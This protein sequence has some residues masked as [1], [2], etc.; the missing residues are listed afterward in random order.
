MVLTH[1]KQSLKTIGIVLGSLD[2][3]CQTN[4]L[5]GIREFAEAHNIQLITFVGV[6]LD[7]ESHYSNS[8]QM[9]G[10]L[11]SSSNVDAVIC[12]GGAMTNL[13]SK[14]EL[15]D[16]T[17]RFLH[18][19][20]VNIANSLSNHINI[21]IDNQFS[22]YT[23]VSH[24]IECHHCKHL[25]FISGPLEHEEAN[26][27][28]LG[29]KAALKEHNILIDHEL[30]FFG[31]FSTYSGKDAVKSL[32][33]EKNRMVDAF[34]CIND[35]TAYGVID[36]LKE[37]NISVPMDVRVTGFDDLPQSTISPTLT[38][39]A[40]PF[41]LL[42][43]K[44]AETCYD[45]LLKRSLP[46]VV[47]VIAHPI[48]RESCGCCSSPLNITPFWEPEQNVSEPF[49]QLTH[50]LRLE[51]LV[52][53]LSPKISHTHRPKILKQLD[54]FMD[55]LV[56]EKSF[57][58]PEFWNTLRAIILNFLHFEVKEG[59]WYEF[60]PYLQLHYNDLTQSQDFYKQKY[61]FATLTALIRDFYEHEAYIALQ[62]DSF[63]AFKLRQFGQKL[64]ASFDMASVLN[65]VEDGLRELCIEECYIVLSKAGCILQ[66]DYVSLIFS[67]KNHIRMT[68]LENK[69]FKVQT[70]L[71]PEISLKESASHYLVMPLIFRNEHFGYVIFKHHNLEA[72]LFETL[73]SH[74]SSGI[75]GSLLY[76]ERCL[77][78]ETLRDTLKQLELANL[79]LK[80]LSIKDEMTNLYNRRGFLE[81]A[82]SY[83]KSAQK[84]NQEFVIY[85]LDLDNLKKIND[86]YGHAEGDHAIIAMS[87]ILQE[88]FT[89]MDFV[90]RLGGDE[91]I[92]LA[93]NSTP[94]DIYHVLRKIHANFNVYNEHCGKSYP[95]STSIGYACYNES[96]RGSL[97][98][99]IDIADMSLYKHKLQ[100]K[101]CSMVNSFER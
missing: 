94:C 85:F 2:E 63:D 48:F 87:Q 86:T 75:K 79:E 29:Y 101:G 99:L 92:I 67:Y 65:I 26:E 13:I 90:A 93:V 97:Q 55:V 66:E 95:L 47:P 22:M 82:N 38:T 78:E 84:V 54:Y 70:I 73:R 45:L 80:H 9:I 17:S 14:K 33:D 83:F 68:L 51:K 74:I 10:N 39:V 32:I 27:R 18:I 53:L 71:P 100:K 37:K 91:F 15:N 4:I 43:I 57:D 77:A 60:L 69:I 72:S 25:A 42:G 7:E 41:R 36:A 34:V 96:F 35:L 59:N 5:A 1:T 16:F 50:H 44:A 20:V 40:Q 30:I 58:T 88:S 6:T 81:I 98:D 24:L 61:L 52:D 49:L 21:L 19:P 56:N 76:A 28:L 62:K 12:M 46:T 8:Y 31:N 23:L 89:P 11:L 64:I 3:S